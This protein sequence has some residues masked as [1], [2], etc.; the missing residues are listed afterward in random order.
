MV[1]K[2]SKKIEEGRKNRKLAER[3]GVFERASR[4]VNETGSV[5]LKSQKDNDLASS[6]P[7]VGFRALASRYAFCRA[8]SLGMS[9]AAT[10]PAEADRHSS[11][12]IDANTPQRSSK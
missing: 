9:L 12:P 8:M 7:F 4:I 5:R 10:S 1:G 11:K 6:S 2:S 3:V